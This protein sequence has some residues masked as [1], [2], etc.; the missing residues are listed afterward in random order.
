MLFVACGWMLNTPVGSVPPLPTRSSYRDRNT[1]Y[2]TAVSLFP[3][4]TP[5]A[6][7]Q[8]SA[9]DVPGAGPASVPPV[10]GVPVALGNVLVEQPVLLA[11]GEP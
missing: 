10:P 6:R 5:Y 3:P 9:S 8:A 2:P 1:G 11:K 7:S 4:D